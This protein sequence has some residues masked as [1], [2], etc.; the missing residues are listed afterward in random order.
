MARFCLFLEPLDCILLVIF[1]NLEVTSYTGHCH[2]S[3][4]LFQTLPIEVKSFHILGSSAVFHLCSKIQ[5]S[6]G[7]CD[8][9]KGSK[10][11]N[12]STVS[13]GC[14]VFLDKSSSNL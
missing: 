12:S 7:Y 8:L 13:D 11:A 10:I 9:L 6:A 1:V 4:F 3:L 14:Q 2:M 5:H